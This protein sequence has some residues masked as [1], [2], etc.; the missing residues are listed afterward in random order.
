MDQDNQI[1][2]D[3]DLSK[4]KIAQAIIKKFKNHGQLSQIKY[5]N[6]LQA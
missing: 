3:Q 6:T 4:L 5:V 1:F 2:A